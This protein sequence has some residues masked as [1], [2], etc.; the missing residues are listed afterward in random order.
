MADKLKLT[1]ELENA[2]EGNSK[3]QNSVKGFS[4]IARKYA[5]TAK[6]NADAT[7][8][9]SS[10][11]SRIAGDEWVQSAPN[12]DMA[13]YL[14]YFST[15]IK[16]VG[17][18]EEK[19]AASVQQE[20]V[21][22]LSNFADYDFKVTAELKKKV[23]QTQ[24]EYDSTCGK[25]ES[26]ITNKSKKAKK[27]ELREQ[28][29]M[30]FER[31]LQR[32]REDL[33]KTQE[34]LQEEQDELGQKKESRVL[35]TVLRLLELQYDYH[36]KSLKLLQNLKPKMDALA[37]QL[38]DSAPVEQPYKEG[39]L[40][41]KGQGIG[42]GWE[43]CFYVLKEGQLYCYRGKKDTQVDQCFNIMLCTTRVNPTKKDVFEL[44][45][46]DK[47]KPIVLQAETQT[48]RD[49]WVKIIQDAISESLNTGAA[50]NIDGS[51]RHS[52]T[53]HVPKSAEDTRNLRIVSARPGNMTCADC[54]CQDPDWASINLGVLV[55]LECSGVHRSLGTHITKVRSMTLDTKS[56][57]PELLWFMRSVGNEAF[58]SVFEAELPP[59]I[60]KPRKSAD[61]EKREKYIKQ[62][63]VEREFVT[64]TDI[65]D[66]DL[67]SAELYNHIVSTSDDVMGILRYLAQG[68]KL[69]WK[70]PQ[71]D[72]KCA[73]HA[74]VVYDR[75]LYLEC[76]IQNGGDVFAQSDSL[77]TPMHFAAQLGRTHCASVLCKHG[78]SKK[79]L[80]YK[81]QDNKTA[82]E[83][84]FINNCQDIITLLRD[85][86]VQG[87]EPTIEDLEA[88]S[89]AEH[90]ELEV[91]EEDDPP[92][93]I[94]PQPAMFATAPPPSGYPLPA[95]SPPP[96]ATPPP[97]A[98]P[99][100]AT[101]P[102]PT[103]TPLSM[104]PPPATSGA[105]PLKPRTGSQTGF[106]LPALTGGRGAPRLRGSVPPGLQR[107]S[108][109]QTSMPIIRDPLPLND[110]P[111]P[112]I[113]MRPSGGMPS[114]VQPPPPAT[115][116]PRM[117]GRSATDAPPVGRPLP[118]GAPPMLPPRDG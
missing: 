87:L 59:E 106:P 56:W 64:P 19:F 13:K 2:L 22:P 85:E 113:P 26:V 97:A 118:T 24:G 72:G 28:Q 63:Y 98:A 36:Q 52:K 42:G 79:Q 50:D 54:N 55:C 45:T 100:P 12:L 111:A 86:P 104:V 37:G 49:D 53:V 71:D 32:L 77:W 82:V 105:P 6:V 4:K 96:A 5:E 23:A 80:E 70:H 29:I 66:P 57:E 35:K 102:P 62:K 101:A 99:P 31:T 30:E 84:A 110:G 9:M 33:D 3:Y 93:P 108:A 88:L 48:E 18:V 68:A 112:I 90:A 58:N 89:E 27:Q 17:C 20:C 76:I 91:D 107:G 39:H 16:A 115:P 109:A 11:L 10:E 47:K 25:I 75:V 103:V 21:D 51:R 61:R 83:L 74:A 1:P 41:R 114:P 14:R 67:L 69:S 44:C 7:N 43:K 73:I 92:P 15:T 38:L 60:A 116:P 78:F 81:T 95:T 46:P 65:F 94:P 34:E 117:P 8:L 40:N